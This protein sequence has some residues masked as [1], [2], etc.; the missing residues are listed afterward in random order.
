MS[1]TNNN[2]HN[3]SDEERHIYLYHVLSQINNKNNLITDTIKELKK[4]KEVNNFYK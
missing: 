4:T 2:I 3:M 1:I